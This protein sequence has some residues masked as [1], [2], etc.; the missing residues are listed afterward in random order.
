MI[1]VN[2]V[3]T[4]IA[5]AV[6]VTGHAH[7]GPITIIDQQNTVDGFTNPPVFTGAGQSFTPALNQINAADFVFA[8][9]S[10]SL[11]LALHSGS[12]IGGPVIATSA[13]VALTGGAFQTV[14][15]NLPLTT[16][17]PGNVYTLFVSA[18]SGT[19]AQEFSRSNPYPGG[20]AF[21]ENGVAAPSVDLVFA[22]GV[23][24]A[25]PEPA[26]LALFG[27]GLAGLAWARRRRRSA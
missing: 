15:F 10:V 12:G 26:S 21:D 5:L 24:S 1:K 11:E 19:F 25:I 6:A 17:I 18:L 22:E 20:E 16:L 14:L 23:T 13:P 27:T 3:I 7:A 8:A 4:I 9:N 2:T